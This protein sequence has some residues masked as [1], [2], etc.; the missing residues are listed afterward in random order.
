MATNE[1]GRNCTQCKEF[2]AW[3]LFHNKP[4]GRN[5]K[6]SQCIECVLKKLKNSKTDRKCISCHLVKPLDEYPTNIR[7]RQCNNCRHDKFL[8]IEELK[9]RSQLVES[10]RK[11]QIY[12]ALLKE[13]EIIDE[14]LTKLHAE[15]YPEDDEKT[16]ELYPFTPT[17]SPPNSPKQPDKSEPILPIPLK[18][19][20]DSLPEISVQDRDV[21]YF[22]NQPLPCKVQLYA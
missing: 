20:I 8:K 21:Q 18:K 22:T 3:N 17:S 2:K 1:E 15:L 12:E 4:K 16:P 9:I 19:I 10:E 11:K 14:R 13:R 7:A 6:N 5:G